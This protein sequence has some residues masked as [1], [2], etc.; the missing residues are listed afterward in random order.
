MHPKA[1]DFFLQGSWLSIGDSTSFD[2]WL[3]SCASHYTLFDGS[4][5]G[6]D[7]NC[8]WDL[9]EVQSYLGIGFYLS[10]YHNQKEFK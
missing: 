2:V 8:V 9:K 10:V 3:T 1:R 4:E 5:V 6:V 7:E